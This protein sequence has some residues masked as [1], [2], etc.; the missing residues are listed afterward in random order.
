MTG[1]RKEVSFEELESLLGTLRM[2]KGLALMDQLNYIV[3]WE[4]S[5]DEDVYGCRISFWDDGGSRR[6]SIS[7]RIVEDQWV[8]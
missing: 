8:D 4:S 7:F 6:Y 3:T 2:L 5:G 1:Q